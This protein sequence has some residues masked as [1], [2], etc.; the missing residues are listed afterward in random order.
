MIS[1]IK[2][3]D[4]VLI[5]LLITILSYFTLFQFLDRMVIQM[6]DEG[7]NA[8]NAYEMIQRNSWLVKYFRGEPDMWETKPPFFIW[9]VIILMKLIGYSELALRIPSAGYTFGSLL[10]MVVFSQNFFRN[11]YI[12]L[13]VSVIMLS[14]YGVVSRHYARTGDNDATLVF[15]LLLSCLSYFRFLHD[16]KHKRKYF[17][18]FM[19]SLFF[20]FFTKSVVGFILLP[21]MFLYTIIARK[22]KYLYTFK[23]VY[24]CSAIFVILAGAYYWYHEQ[25]T[26]GYFKVVFGGEFGAGVRENVTYSWY[27]IEN[28]WNNRFSKWLLFL[29]VALII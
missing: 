29:P 22:L 12:G 17:Y 10:V 6:W 9:H 4:T 23:D 3:F 8:I 11:K 28:F 14:S 7:Q 24:W 15:Y 19:A 1:K 18:I 27:Y 26:P 16:T 13:V 20:A 25:Q 5:Y 21:G 2:S